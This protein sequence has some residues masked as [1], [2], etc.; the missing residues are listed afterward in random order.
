[1]KTFTPKKLQYRTSSAFVRYFLLILS[2]V[3]I[4][5]SAFSLYI[6]QMS[7]K[8]FSEQQSLSEQGILNQAI[9]SM[10]NS[11]YFINQLAANVSN[12]S[13]VINSCISPS[14]ENW[15]RNF[16]VI[17][18][19]KN[20]VENNTYLKSAYLYEHTKGYMLT[21]DSETTTLSGYYKSTTILYCLSDSSSITLEEEKNQFCSRLVQDGQK[22]FLVYDF[23]YSSKGPLNTL[24]LELDSD[25]LLSGF[26]DTPSLSNYYV[27]ILGNRSTPIYSSI[28]ETENSNY[29]KNNN[30]L[31][32]ASSYTQLNYYLYPRE[33]NGFSLL[34]SN[35]M[36][37]PMVLLL[38]GVSLLLTW[39]IT[40]RFYS[41]VKKLTELIGADKS[42]QI[43]PAPGTNEFDYLENAY[44]QLILD[45][46]QASDLLEKVRPELEQK[47]FSSILD[48][49]E[50]SCQELEQQL[51]SFHSN[52]GVNE[53]YQVAILQLQDMDTQDPLAQHLYAQHL[54]RLAE[55]LFQTEWGRLMTLPHGWRECILIIQYPSDFSMARIKR[56]TRN[57]ESSLKKECDTSSLQLSVAFGKVYYSLPEIRHSHRDATLQLR[58]QVYYHDDAE[59]TSDAAAPAAPD[60]ISE[61]YFSSRILQFSQN[62]DSGE[63]ALSS[64][65][66]EHLLDELS[67]CDL[68][69]TE[70]K[71]ICGQILDVLV[72]KSLSYPREESEQHM[73]RYP[74]LYQELQN[75]ADK[76]SLIALM[77]TETADLISFILS[78]SQKRQ[79]RLIARA[80]DF[81]SA[82]YSNSNLS[83]NDIAQD[84]GCS[85]SYLSNVFTEYAHENLVTY[86]NTYRVN[87]ARDL[88]LNSQILIKDI[89]F[90]TGFNTVQNFNRV[91]KKTTGMTPNEYRK[92]RQNS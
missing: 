62:L 27:T 83:I 60:S 89:G 32:L 90:K 55:Q 87:M 3:F 24:I 43:S 1:M 25:E 64:A 23:V 50:Y 9:E 46:R 63:T 11:F 61:N 69:L 22:L 75:A 39:F 2:L 53:K 20:L 41:P 31:S 6:Y 71:E 21:S 44:Q 26:L 17:T 80:K 28:T 15:Q 30:V 34:R 33:S 49:T 48:G 16:S 77:R 35:Q 73:L 84:A 38:L 70:R 42:S 5:L 4:L 36:F 54:L 81:I 56:L 78:E 13:D 72:E 29:K 12:N 66:L 58:Y 74:I 88:L 8:N 51:N 59:N 79:H 85:P 82:N 65:L 19:L 10:D 86:L 91:F 14:Q 40:C 52:F 18:T 67:D 45:R 76:D 7:Y 47:L 57:F 37:L 92:S 68:A